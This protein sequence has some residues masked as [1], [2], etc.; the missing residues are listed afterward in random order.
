MDSIIESIRQNK[1]LVSAVAYAHF[2]TDMQREE[3]IE[4][5]LEAIERYAE[6]N[7]IVLVGHY[8]DRAESARTD[9]RPEFQR[10]LIDSKNGSFDV[11]LVHKLDRFTRSKN[12]SVIIRTELKRNKVDV[13]SVCENIDNSPEALI[14]QSVI[15]AMAEYYSLNLAR[16]TMKGLRQ[17]ALK[18]LH[19][20]GKPPLGYDVDKATKKLVINP[21]E[22]KIVKLIFDMVSDGISYREVIAELNRR[23]YKTKRGGAFGKNSLH[24]LLRNE[25][26]TGVLVFNR[27]ATFDVDRKRN[28]H[29]NKSNDEIIRVE[30]AIPCIVSRD[31]FDKVQMILASRKQRKMSNRRKVTYLM[32]GLIYCGECGYS[33]SGNRVYSKRQDATYHSYRC[34]KGS[35]KLSCKNPSIRREQIENFALQKLADYIFDDKLIPIVAEEYRQLQQSMYEE[36]TQ[37]AKSLKRDL[38]EVQKQINNIVIVVATTSSTTLLDKLSELEAQQAPISFELRHLEKQ[39]HLE[40]QTDEELAKHFQRARILFGD[41]IKP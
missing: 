24:D 3:S 40:L 28:N 11:V 23:D 34:T 39:I 8:C 4:A 18:G 19:T 35:N 7:N 17:N 2:S 1:Q 26:Y 13:V 38:H 21:H 14:L 36:E 15:E 27:A 12:D 41:K 10:M 5:Q 31:T 29:A 20:G 9:K 30:D 33:M 32:S 6:Q 16:E 25:K 22:S 37:R